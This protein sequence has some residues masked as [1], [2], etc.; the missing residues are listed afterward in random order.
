MTAYRSRGAAAPV[1]WED[2]ITSQVRP[3]A[4]MPAA[5]R[6]VSDVRKNSCDAPRLLAGRCRTAAS[7]DRRGCAGLCGAGD[8]FNL[9]KLRRRGRPLGCAPHPE[10]CVEI[11]QQGPP[12]DGSQVDPEAVDRQ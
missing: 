3:A 4:F 6:R 2:K 8:L 12:L 5:T 10:E 11:G 7:A 9:K 1:P